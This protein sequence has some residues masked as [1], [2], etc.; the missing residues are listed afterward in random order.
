[1]LYWE[2]KGESD[3]TSARGITGATGSSNAG[4]N[5]T[6]KRGDKLIE[7]IYDAAIEIIR[8]EGYGSL[9]FL[10]ISRLARTGRTV[11]YR[12]WATP[13]DLI[14]EIMKYRSMQA[15]G[16]DL[17]DLI[18]DTGSLRGDLLYLLDLYQKI[19]VSV[20]PEIMN[21][22]LFEMSQNNMRI[23]A[24]KNDIGFRNVEMMGKLL[25]FAK[26]RGEKISPVSEKTLRLPFDLIRMS[27]L[28]ERQTMG[29]AERKQL[30]DEILLPVYTGKKL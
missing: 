23:P 25:E 21:A 8:S 2:P 12:R 27:F 18:K 16:G 13:L 28:W 5:I 14:R 24:I 15:L 7:S 9:T 11:L 30:V 4:G 17:P 26:A 22:M 6:R 20:G 29:E 3:M 19:Y 1:M 10:R